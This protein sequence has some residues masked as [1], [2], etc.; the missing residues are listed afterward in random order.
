ML[1][2][3]VNVS[4]NAA[5]IVRDR[6]FF[7]VGL[8]CVY[9]S[10]SMVGWMWLLTW[11]QS[12]VQAAQV[13]A[14]SPWSMATTP[15][16]LWDTSSLTPDCTS[17]SLNKSLMRS[18]TEALKLSAV[19]STTPLSPWSFATTPEHL[20]DTSSCTPTSMRSSPLRTLLASDGVSLPPMKA[21][22]LSSASSPLTSHTA[23]VM[24][25]TPSTFSALRLA[26][27]STDPAA[28]SPTLQGKAD[29]SAGRHSVQHSL[30]AGLC[31]AKFSGSPVAGLCRTDSRFPVRMTKK[32]K[33]RYGCR[34]CE[35]VSA[36]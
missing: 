9:T 13:P 2:C 3:V 19:A 6:R 5:K 1:L 11:Q 28:D 29:A 22:E 20:W 8:P 33:V 31:S 36:V 23:A 21:L 4:S 27:T 24:T 12:D 14:V 30:D 18:S 26:G 10:F 32:Q 35:F 16:H 34:V 17:S 25:S 15:E 7:D